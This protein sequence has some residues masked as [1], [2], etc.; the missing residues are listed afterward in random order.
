MTAHHII[1]ESDQKQVCPYC[2]NKHQRWESVFD[3]HN[4]YKEHR[5]TCGRRVMIKM[6]FMGSGDDSWSKNLDRMIEEEE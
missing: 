5:C 3:G 6:S 4:H 2:G 1:Q